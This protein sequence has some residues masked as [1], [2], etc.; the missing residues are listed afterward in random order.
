M[1]SI[2]LPSNSSRTGLHLIVYLLVL[3]PSDGKKLLVVPMDGS[4]WLSMRIVVEEMAQR[5]HDVVVLVPQ[6]SLLIEA[7]SSYKLQHFPVPYSKE[8]LMGHFNGMTEDILKKSPFLQKFIDVIM[9]V[10]DVTNLLYTT[11]ESLLLNEKLMESLKKEN[12]DILLNDPFTPCGSILAHYL[13]VPLIH[14]MKT[15]PCG[16]EYEATQCPSPPS[17][18]PRLLLGFSD[19]MTF[20]QQVINFLNALIEPLFCKAIYPSFGDLAKKVLQKDISLQE[21]VSYASIW[22]LRYDFVMEHPRPLMP[23]IVLIGGINC[24]KSNHLPLEFMNYI[25]KSGDHGIVVFS[26][27]SAI[28]ELTL[29]LATEFADAFGKIPQTVLWRYTGPVPPNLAENTKV[30]KWLPQNDLLAHPKTRAFITHGG[31]HGIYEAICNGVPMIMVPLFG[32]QPGNVQRMERRGAGIT[33]SFHDI[34]S[35]KLLDALEAVINTTR[36]KDR[37]MELSAV[38]KDRPVEPLDLAVHWIEFV[39]RHK[40]A[41]HLRPAAHDLN[42]IQYHSLD[43]IAFLAAIILIVVYIEFKCCLFCCKKLFCKRF[44]QKSKSE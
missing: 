31:S 30:L 28:S 17:Y 43:V 16:L 1:S 4:H 33:L 22:L 38:H 7:S 15:I 35:Q 25:N 18:V 44:Q 20:F 5:G 32:D 8:D 36:Y 2:R 3:C 12:F 41:N 9:H 14:F 27:G 10:R 34:T 11:C 42:W 21:M 24:K 26:L 40:G 6:A 23:N 37:M 19:H 29:E 13:S 39:M